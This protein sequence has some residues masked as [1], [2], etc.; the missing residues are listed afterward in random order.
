MGHQQK[1]ATAEGQVRPIADAE[2]ERG[3]RAGGA[4]LRVLAL[5]GLGQCKETF[6]ESQ[7]KK[8][9][10]AKKLQCVAELVYVDAPRPDPRPAYCCCRV[11][12]EPEEFRIDSEAWRTMQEANCVGIE[13]SLAYLEDVWSREGPFDGIL[14]FSSG[15]SFGACFVDYMQRRGGLGPRFIICGSGSYTPIPVNVPEYAAYATSEKKI[16]V[17]SFHTM[18]KEDDICPPRLSKR[19]ASIF[20]DAQVLEIE[21]GKHRLP[22]RSVDCAP[23]VSFLKQFF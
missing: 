14:G 9:C 8:D 15:A 18:G 22:N 20:H 21:E 5:H 23:I 12:Y 11:Y 1:S 16:M 2:K 7:E 4:R 17:P 3:P 10:L 19:L 6:K 13:D